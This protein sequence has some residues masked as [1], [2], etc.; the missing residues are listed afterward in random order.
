MSDKE[1]FIHKQEHNPVAK[2]KRT[3]SR[4]FDGS[5][6]QD[7]AVDTSGRLEVT[8]VAGT[9]ANDLILETR[10]FNGAMAMQV[11]DAGSGTLYQGWAEPGTATSASSWRIRRIVTSGT[12]EDTAITFADGNRNFDNIWDD[13]AVLSYS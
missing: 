1:A 10:V 2:S 6:Y 5:D 9:S 11:D 8:V 7:I 4:G 3:I 13:R 12:P